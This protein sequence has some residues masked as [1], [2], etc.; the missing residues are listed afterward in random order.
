MILLR[1]ESLKSYNAEEAHDESDKVIA[2]QA[3]YN[4]ATTSST[5]RK[6]FYYFFLKIVTSQ[7]SQKPML[8]DTKLVNNYFHSFYSCH[9]FSG[10]SIQIATWGDLSPN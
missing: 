6:L 4:D 9:N 10:L 1:R 5:A 2:A 3:V 8:G 7:P